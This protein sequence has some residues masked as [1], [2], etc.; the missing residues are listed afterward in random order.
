MRVLVEEDG[1]VS[2]DFSWNDLTLESEEDARARA[3]TPSG[4]WRRSPHCVQ[5]DRILLR[6]YE[7]HGPRWAAA[8]Q[9]LGGG[10]AGFSEDVVRGRVKRLLGLEK[11]KTSKPKSAL[12]VDP[13]WTPEE[14][15]RLLA[16]LRG[17]VQRPNWASVASVCVLS[18]SPHATRNRARRLRLGGVA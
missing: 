12:S 8:S 5:T 3:E 9:L 15:A 2:V 7:K 6:F 18:R 14:D 1:D 17:C 4:R 11:Y 13:R 16:F 10:A